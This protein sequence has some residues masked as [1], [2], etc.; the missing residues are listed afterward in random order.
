MT[1]PA[2]LPVADRRTTAS[3]VVDLLRSRRTLLVAAAVMFTAGAASSLVGPLALGT[4]VDRVLDGAP[5]DAITGPAALVAA[6]AAVQGLLAMA[7]PAVAAQALE[8]ALADLREAVV[9][10]S[11]RLPSDTIERSGTGDLVARVDGD[12][13]V[14][15]EAA[16]SAFPELVTAGLTI[17][18]TMVGLAALDWRLGLAALCAV[19]I[20][21][22]TLRW[23]LPRSSPL[24]AAER[25]AAGARAE[26]VLETVAGADTVR[27]L[28]LAD[29]QVG[30]VE[31][32]SSRAVDLVVAATR[33]R[34]R[35]FARL[36]LAE[37]TGMAAIL[38]VGFVLVDRG[39]LTVGA[40]TAAV[41]FFQ[42]LFDPINVLLYLVDEAQAAGAALGRLVGITS[43]PAAALPSVTAIGPAT[44]EIDD[45]V[46]S[47]EAG[48]PVL[49]GV[50][51]AV[52]AGERVAI[53]GSS[54]AGKST[55]AKVLAA[56]HPV[57]HGSVTVAGAAVA[58]LAS[59]GG[60]VPMVLV[61]QEVHVHA[62]T[63][64]EDLRLAA[65][66]ARDADLERALA[67][68]GADD[69]VRLLPE[70]METRVGDGGR[71]LTAAHAQQLAL[72]RLV[73]ADPAVAILD[74][75]TADAGSA[76]ARVLDVAADAALAGRTAVV[77]A[78][79]L[80]QA[81]AADR[82]IVLEGGRVVQTGTH[83]ELV[84]SGG[85]YAKLWRAWAGARSV[86]PGAGPERP[87]MAISA[88]PVP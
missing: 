56:M 77:V 15:A 23:Y 41:L 46:H 47:Y 30:L 68:V 9:D 40:V 3:A 85:P 37:V 22:H 79:R 62:G 58:D 2:R 14:V 60:R 28:R 38:A 55:L 75:A 42:R 80:S 8:P 4:I 39:T 88:E 36:N 66:H 86:G 84:A 12:V 1:S 49:H 81:A 11:L 20:Q 59:V 73:L 51:L 44:I 18:L 54:G 57:E 25:E 31:E 74:E 71:A 69:W 78:H 76:G 6:A 16:R 26:Q 43:I 63:I 70:G 21:L 82:I 48:R 65:P 72:A 33:L 7:A 34:T 64:A 27:A 67:A 53:V 83:E 29:R 52:A 45:L 13:G 5:A 17:L 19:P 24:Y 10:R 50:D 32:R 61:T 35:F 87:A